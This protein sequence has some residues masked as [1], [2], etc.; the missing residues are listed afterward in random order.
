MAKRH[1]K[2]CSI[3]LSGKCNSKPQLDATSHVLER[4]LSKSNKYQVFERM[5]RKGNP[6]RLLVGLWIGT[7]TMIQQYR[8]SSKFFLK[9]L[10]YDPSISVLSICLKQTKTLISTHTHT[11]THTHTLEYYSAM[12]N[13]ILP[14]ATTWMD[15]EGIILSEISETEK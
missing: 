4:L 5:W 3:S 12:K 1:M 9:D 6:H 13:K 10:I 8:L 7:V 2:R 15:L 11:H 14:F